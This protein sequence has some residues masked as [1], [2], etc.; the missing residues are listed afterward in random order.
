MEHLECEVYGQSAE[1]RPLRA[2]RIPG[3]HERPV[4]VVGGV[5][6]LEFI[7]VLVAEAVARHRGALESQVETWVVPVA[8][9]DAYHHCREARGVGK[10]SVFR[11]NARGVDLNRNFPL[12]G[13]ARRWPIWVTGSSNPKAATYYG[14]G[15]FSEPETA[16]LAGLLRRIQPHALTSLHSFGGALI[17]ARVKDRAAWKVYGQL[18]KAYREARGRGRIVRLGSR[19]FD[20]FAGELEDWAH[21]ELGCW[22]TCVEL[23]PLWDSVRQNG[24]C[25]STFRRF[26]PDNPSHVL[27]LDTPAVWAWLEEARR[28]PRPKIRQIEAS[29]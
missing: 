22:S 10:A 4:V 27:H 6:G 23:F 21:H 20:A 18:S 8:N 3:E 16:S 2:Y 9:P 15:P 11:K 14:P 19:I 28:H 1:G 26:N 29:G 24:V 17:H 5:H 13:G 25:S 7:G 12:P